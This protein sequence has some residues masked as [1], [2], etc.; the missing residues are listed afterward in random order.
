MNKFLRNAVITA[1]VL[2][3][4]MMC[5]FVTLA[6][7]DYI[8]YTAEDIVSEGRV[9]TVTSDAKYGKLTGG[10]VMSQYTD[11][12]VRFMTTSSGAASTSSDRLIIEVDRIN[13]TEYP[14]VIISYNTNINAP[15]LNYNR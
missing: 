6:A 4:I 3:G 7:D 15:N 10:N 8:V 1:L 2:C 5:T 13:L 14:Y 11:G 12:F 9:V